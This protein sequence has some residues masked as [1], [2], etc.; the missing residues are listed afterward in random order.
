MCKIDM[1]N[2][3]IHTYI[4]ITW[5]IR[6]VKWASLAL[7]LTW[8]AKKLVRKDLYWIEKWLQIKFKK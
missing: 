2:I 6:D 8:T 4:C 5:H 3:H 7:E 1:R